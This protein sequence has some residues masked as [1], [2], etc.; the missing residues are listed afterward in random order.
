MNAQEREKA[1]GRKPD[2]QRI[3]QILRQ[4]RRETGL[5]DLLSFGFGRAWSVLLIAT[6]TFVVVA[7]SWARTTGRDDGTVSQ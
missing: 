6:A 2:E 7:D 3:Q 1:A 5:K 4:V